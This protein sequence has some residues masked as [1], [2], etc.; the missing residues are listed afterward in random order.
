M[1]ATRMLPGRRIF[2]ASSH[3]VVS[4]PEKTVVLWPEGVR[5]STLVTNGA[6][7]V[8]NISM[9]VAKAGVEKLTRS[10][11]GFAP[12]P[13]GVHAKTLSSHCSKM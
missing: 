6:L 12:L 8:S 1:C 4:G 3:P 11:S 10:H 9:D 2:R 13:K 5:T 7:E